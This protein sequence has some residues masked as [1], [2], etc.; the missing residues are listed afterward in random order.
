MNSNMGALLKLATVVPALASCLLLSGVAEASFSSASL[1]GTYGYSFNKW[2]ADTTQNE[3]NSVGIF[4]FDGVSAVTYSET[5]NNAGSIGTE[6]GSGTYSVKANGIGTMTLTNSGNGNSTTFS[7]SITSAGKRFQI[8]QTSCHGT[9]NNDVNTGIAVA[10]LGTS[11]NNGSLKGAFG[12]LT[13]TWTPTSTIPAD[14]NIGIV[15]FDGISKVTASITDNQAGAVVTFSASGSYSVNPDGSGNL[16]LTNKAGQTTTVSF[17][18]N[19]AGSQFQYLVTSCGGT[20][21]NEVQGGTAI[22]Q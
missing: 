7:I 5:D 12:F 21:N 20:C 15:T 2:T 13:N 22:H 8:V 17:V 10:Q 3:I 4:T 16:S 19:S 9:C 14:A 6:S 18:L 11:F 1:K